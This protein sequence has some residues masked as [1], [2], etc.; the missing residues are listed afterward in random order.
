MRIVHT[1]DLHIGKVLNEFSLLEDQRYILEQITGILRE[2]RADVLVIAGDLYDRAIPSAEGVRLLD[3]FLVRVTGELKIP[4]L[5]ISG[6]HDSG[7]RVAFASRLL[8]RAG[9]FLA[10]LPRSSPQK[11]TL[12]DQYGEVDFYLLPFVEPATVRPLLPPEQAADIHSYD[13]AVGAVVDPLLRQLD[14]GRRSVLVAHGMF[15]AASSSSGE[16]D[17]YALSDG[18]EEVT[19][20]GADLVNARRFFPFDYAA[21]G[22]LHSPLTAGTDWVRFSG[23]PLAYSIS[24]GE[25]AE[26]G[27]LPREKSVTLV[28]L[29]KKGERTVTPISLTPLHRMVI[30]TGLFQDFL[31]QPPTEDYL[32]LKLRDQELIPDAVAR[33]RH[34]FPRLLGIRLLAR[35]AELERRV[36]RADAAA[37]RTP[38]ALFEEF[39]SLVTGAPLTESQRELF[40]DAL[41]QAQGP[42]ERH[43]GTE[44]KVLQTT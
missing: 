42:Q 40:A 9:L 11:V 43:S 31:Q 29:G 32:F 3:E 7:Q 22:H 44:R 17:R 16:D 24:E 34:S 30:R 10:G 5:A 20:G 6:N 41:R 18:L 21:L 38:Q 37:H 26:E 4:V 19:V 1:A 2:Y 27:R 14:A 33:L 13:Q 8:D 35:D 15:A 12:P 39:F 36:S 28:E 23:S 25:Q